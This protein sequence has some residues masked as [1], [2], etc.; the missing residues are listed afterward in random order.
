MY[1]T[2]PPYGPPPGGFQPRPPATVPG[3]CGFQAPPAS[4]PPR[5]MMMPPPW[6]PGPERRPPPPTMDS[7]WPQGVAWQT[8][9][10][11]PIPGTPGMR[12]TSEDSMCYGA[13]KQSEALHHASTVWK[14]RIIADDTYWRMDQRF[15][16]AEWRDDAR[17]DA[18]PL[19]Q[20]QANELGREM[21]REQNRQGGR[22]PE[23]YALGE[24]GYD[25][26][27]PAWFLNDDNGGSGP[28]PLPPPAG[29]SYPV[30]GG[31]VM[32]PLPPQGSAAAQA[33]NNAM[34][35]SFAGGVQCGESGYQY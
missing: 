9:P 10:T 3:P 15:Q 23:G 13:A 33:Q 35:R 2:Q 22:Q 8:W 11:P 1:G 32:Y 30:K 34:V 5:S 29:R 6:S 17:R 20:A 27:G 19:I 24:H 31:T 28:P 21:V 4:M 12:W 26:R 16:N 7:P 14:D 25:Y 18:R